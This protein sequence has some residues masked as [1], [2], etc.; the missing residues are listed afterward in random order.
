MAETCLRLMGY[1]GNTWV[2]IFIKV[3]ISARFDRTVNKTREVGG[4]CNF[5]GVLGLLS[6]ATVDY[7]IHTLQNNTYDGFHTCASNSKHDAYANIEG[8][9]IIVDIL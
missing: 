4:R 9:T 5:S 3:L 7:Q 1:M 8:K 2:S 6:Q